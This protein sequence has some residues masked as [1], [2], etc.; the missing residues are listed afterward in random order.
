MREKMD[1]IA[2]FGNNLPQ[3][4]RMW[5]TIIPKAG[6]TSSMAEHNCVC[7]A[8]QD[9]LIGDL[10]TESVSQSLTDFWFQRLHCKAFLD[11]CDLSDN[12]QQEDKDIGSNIVIYWPSETADYSWQIARLKSRHWGLV[13][14]SQRV[15]WTA[16]PILSMSRSQEH[17]EISVE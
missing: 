11:T 8:V 6:V 5:N 13:I 12:D 10:V 9:S 14:D 1:A 3:Y 7:S 2:H 17:E 4:P 15:T 16:I